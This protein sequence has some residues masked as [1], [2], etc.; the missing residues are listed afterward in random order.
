MFVVVV[1]QVAAYRGHFAFPGAAAAAQAAGMTT[2]PFGYTQRRRLADPLP[3]LSLDRGWSAVE[4]EVSSFG[5]DLGRCDVDEVTAISVSCHGI[6]AI[7]VAFFSRCQRRR[8]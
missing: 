8:C 6:A 4:A 2:K 7:W 5:L 1:G 3:A